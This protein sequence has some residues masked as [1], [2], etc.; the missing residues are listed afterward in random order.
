MISNMF[1]MGI[2]LA[3]IMIVYNLEFQRRVDYF[4]RMDLKENREQLAML[5]EELELRVSQRTRDVE[6]SNKDLQ[7]FVY[8]ISHD[9][10]EPLRQVSGYMSLIERRYAEQLDQ[11]GREFIDFAVDGA[12][13]MAMMIDRLLAFFPAGNAGKRVGPGGL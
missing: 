8:V 12:N 4:I 6:N 10:K 3:G 2:N 5:N 9:L 1:V 13:R 7:D 11:S